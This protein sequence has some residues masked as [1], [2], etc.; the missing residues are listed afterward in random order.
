MKYKIK[1]RHLTIAALVITG[2]LSPSVHAVA[3]MENIGVR[4][5]TLTWV[6][7]SPSLGFDVQLDQQWQ[8]NFDF[9]I[10]IVNAG[11]NRINMSGF[12]SEIRRYFGSSYEGLYLGFGAR[13]LKYNKQ[14]GNDPGRDGKLTLFGVTGGYVFNIG[15]GWSIDTNIGLGYVHDEYSRYDWYEPRQENRLLYGNVSDHFGLT[16][17]ELSIVYHFSLNGNKSK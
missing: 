10:G 17:A 3:Q 4:T 15:K 7:L 11:H 6:A 16:N 12:G 13:Y 5:N 2:A 8:A 9:N 1:I 14:F